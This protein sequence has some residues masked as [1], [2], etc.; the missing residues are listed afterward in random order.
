MLTKQDAHYLASKNQDKEEARIAVSVRN[1]L[2]NIEALAELGQF[3]LSSEWFST[4]DHQN[5]AN[6]VQGR[7]LSLGYDVIVAPYKY[8]PGQVKSEALDKTLSITISWK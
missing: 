7:L 1:I 5:Y 4:T 2:K 3:E 6:S 8:A